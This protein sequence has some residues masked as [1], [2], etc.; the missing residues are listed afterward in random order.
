V[1]TQ[2]AEANCW[3]A[4]KYELGNI[5]GQEA[6]EA[7]PDATWELFSPFDSHQPSGRARA[8][9]S[10][11]HLEFLRLK[12]LWEMDREGQRQLPHASLRQTEASREILEHSTQSKRGRQIVNAYVE[13]RKAL[14]AFAEQY[15]LLGAFEEDFLGP[16]VLPD[17]KTLVAPEAVIDDRGRVRRV[18]PA[19]EGKEL[20]L[21]V[22][23]PAGHFWYFGKTEHDVKHE[24]MALPSEIKFS[25]RGPY[26]D[27][28]EWPV[29]PRQL[30]PWEDISK[31]FGALLILDKR[32]TGGVSI[33]CTREPLR[34]WEMSFRFFPSG[35]PPGA[36]ELDDNSYVSL[37]SYLE[38]VSPHAFVGEDGTLEQGW[39]YR[40]L[41]QA[42]Y[43]MLYLDLTGGSTL[44]K[45]ESRG[46]PN[47]FRVGPQSKSKYCS[48]R[49]A[50]RASTRMGR[51]QEP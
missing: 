42:M 2:H 50:N 30:V 39:R 45:C 47:Y 15:G 48:E 10:G 21:K 38:D 35:V 46:C 9:E 32:V 26:L 33:L 40:S 19:T 13:F 16:P 5:D 24:T 28:I 23:E 14:I 49:C 31:Y 1:L 12:R 29:E 22:L 11:P 27:R 36:L 7:T 25:S 6:I 20:L 18:D 51:G 41:L 8:L 17:G 44:K 37:N 43:V 4:T 3:R 34:R